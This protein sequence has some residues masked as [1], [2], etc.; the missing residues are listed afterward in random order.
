[1]RAGNEI[2]EH[3]LEVFGAGD[4]EGILKDYDE[5]SIMVYGN[6][7][8]FGLAGAKDFFTM[9]LD[10]LI[11][12]GSDFNVIDQVSLENILYITWTANSRNYIFDYGT[13]TFIFKNDKI[14][15]QT[16]ATFLRVKL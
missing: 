11:P 3:H 15:R 6:K 7:T 4:I 2:F 5:T 1:M 8:W 13:N 14:W 16:V 12:A 9:W 10:D